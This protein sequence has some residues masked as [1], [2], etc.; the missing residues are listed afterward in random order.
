MVNHKI[1]SIFICG[2]CTEVRAIQNLQFSFNTIFRAKW[3][4]LDEPEHI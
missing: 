3:K 1:S 2:E 4:E